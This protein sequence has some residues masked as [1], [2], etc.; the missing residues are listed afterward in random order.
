[1]LSA[2]VVS[3]VPALQQT[4]LPYKIYEEHGVAVIACTTETT[5]SIS[6]PGD[7][8]QFLDVVTSVQHAID[9]IKA[10]TDIKRIVALTHIGYDED[11]R[12]ARETTGLSLIM[13][14]HSHTNLGN[15]DPAASQG[16]YPTI[17]ENAN[18]D[19]VF[20]VT[21]WRWGQYLGFI[22]VVFD[23][24]GRAISYTGGPINLDNTTEQDAALQAQIDEWRVPFEEFAAEVIGYSEVDLVQSTCQT[25]ECTLGNVMTDAIVAYRS[26]VADFSLINAGGIRAAIDVGNVTRGEVLTSFPFGNAITEFPMSGADVL[27][28]LEGCV[29]RVSQFNGNPVTSGF[30]VSGSLKVQYNPSLPVGGRLV[31]ALINGVEVDESATYTVATLDFLAGGGDNIFPKVASPVVLDLQADVLERYIQAQSPINIAVEGR[32]EQVTEVPGDGGG[33]SSSTVSSSTITASATASASVTVSG[34]VSTTASVSSTM[35]TSISS[36]VSETVSSLSSSS[37][38]SSTATAT[39]STSGVYPTKT[40]GCGRR[41]RPTVN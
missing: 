3:T 21:A 24:E 37:S 40:R 11:Q 5:A 16:A 9:E 8:T 32:I 28:L 34:T 15:I 35:V 25:V 10:T 29:S 33:S 22:D 38:S 6:N 30:Q 41:P 36:S 13:G 26:G 17:V 20:V 4:I 31:R 2:N 27:R 39:S 12:L 7:Q 1:M 14:G 18:G 19:E 23:A